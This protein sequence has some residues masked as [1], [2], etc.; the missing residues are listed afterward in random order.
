[1]NAK[2]SEAEA[3]V[4]RGEYITDEELSKEIETWFR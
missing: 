1:M 2:D 3:K 4:E